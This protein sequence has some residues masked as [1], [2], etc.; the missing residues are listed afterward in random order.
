MR[1]IC[2]SP[3]CF[4]DISERASLHPRTIRCLLCNHLMH[5]VRLQ[6][7][8][9]RPHRRKQRSEYAKQ[10]NRRPGTIRMRK[11]AQN[12]LRLRDRLERNEKHLRRLEYDREY[13][14]KRER[15]PTTAPRG[16]RPILR[17]ARWIPLD[18]PDYLK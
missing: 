4:N 6:V 11:E 3:G 14:K 12:A 9:R 5:L 1:R 16:D 17:P 13:N 2:R 10:A 7:A 18:V 15:Q 8:R